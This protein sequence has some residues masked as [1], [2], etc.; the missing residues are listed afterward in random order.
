MALNE[1]SLVGEARTPRAIVK[2]EGEIVPCAEFEVD[3]NSF[4]QAN[5]FR[6]SLPLSALPPAR[7]WTFWSE[8]DAVKVE[9]YA[10]FPDD[11]EAYTVDDLDLILV[12]ETDEVDLKPVADEVCLTGRD[13]TSRFIEET[14][15]EKFANLTAAELVK[16]LAER[17][18]LKADVTA[19]D[20]KIGTFLSQDHTLLTTERTEWD[21]LTYAAQEEG[22]LLY[23]EGETVHFHP[24]PDEKSEAYV[25]NYSR[26]TEDSG[27]WSNTVTIDFSR[28]LTLARDVVVAVRS[29]NQK[30]KKGFTTT[31][32][33]SKAKRT[34]SRGGTAQTYVATV[35]N[36]TE[37]DAIKEAR[38]RLKEITAHEIR[39]NAELPADNLIKTNTPIRVEG[40]D[41]RF[42]QVYFVDHLV[43]TYTPDRGYF[44]VLRAKNHS[45]ESQVLA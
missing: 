20:R 17:R 30:A 34:Q 39:L 2:V 45:T 7:S 36:L 13:Y 37:E 15:T 44:M 19:T 23:V 29:W 8:A 35:P 10:G 1:I 27:A 5:T 43:R 31:A 4:Y 26:A 16:T 9:I 40:T 22:Y 41:T 42:D 24:P 18:G 6:L 38:R 25:L 12:G 21:L 11:P 33:A 3:S 14:T 28:S 32:R